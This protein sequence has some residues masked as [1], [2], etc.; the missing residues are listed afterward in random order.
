MTCCQTRFLNGAA[1]TICV[2]LV[3][4]GAFLVFWI[5]SPRNPSEIRFSQLLLLL[6]HHLIHGAEKQQASETQKLACLEQKKKKTPPRLF[7]AHTKDFK[8]QKET[9]KAIQAPCFFWPTATTGVLEYF[10]LISGGVREQ[11]AA[12]AK[13]K[14]ALIN[15]LWQK[16]RWTKHSP[17]AKLAGK[18][19]ATYTECGGFA[20]PAAGT[21]SS[22][23]LRLTAHCLGLRHGA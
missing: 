9:I 20:S 15:A 2:L 13:K 7:T 22:V 21:L 10:P 14:A 17:R 3:N 1:A 8:L 19:L 18:E 6:L 5:K 11:K 23:V 4:T 12:H 16:T